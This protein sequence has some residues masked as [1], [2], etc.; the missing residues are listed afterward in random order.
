MQFENSFMTNIINNLSMA[1]SQQ[2]L[3]TPM[4]KVTSTRELQLTIPKFSCRHLQ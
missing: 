2:L 1:T 3:Q 4:T